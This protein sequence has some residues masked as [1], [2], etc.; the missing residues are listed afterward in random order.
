MI[1]HQVPY[2]LITWGES[3]GRMPLYGAMQWQIF[4]IS[5]FDTDFWKS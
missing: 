5:E 1:F 3:M 2:F 4:L